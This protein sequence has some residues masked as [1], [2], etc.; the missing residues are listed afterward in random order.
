MG[1]PPGDKETTQLHTLLSVYGLN[2]RYATNHPQILKEV[3][4]HDRRLTLCLWPEELAGS[5]PGTQL[6]CHAN[7]CSNGAVGGPTGV[8]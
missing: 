1:L 5:R 6:I 8:N 2:N 3:T 4:I 7:S